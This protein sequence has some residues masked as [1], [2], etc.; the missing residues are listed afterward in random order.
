MTAVA[1]LLRL[2]L[3]RHIERSHAE[4]VVLAAIAIHVPATLQLDLISED[5]AEAGDRAGEQ[6]GGALTYSLLLRTARLSTYVDPEHLVQAAEHAADQALRAKYGEAATASAGLA[7]TSARA[8]GPGTP[9]T[10]VRRTPVAGSASC[11]GR[12]SPRAGERHA[13]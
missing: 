5:G 9:R 1:G 6:P 8:A 3:P 11:R 7:G 2:H 10:A 4:A 12:T 13:R